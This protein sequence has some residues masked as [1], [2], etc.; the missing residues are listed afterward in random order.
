MP[1]RRA[2]SGGVERG[3][4]ERPGIWSFDLWVNER[5]GNKFLWEGKNRHTDRH[6]HGQTDIPTL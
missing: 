1:H 4:N 6:T 5:P 2:L 3:T